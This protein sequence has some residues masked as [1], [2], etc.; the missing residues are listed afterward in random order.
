MDD[1]LNTKVINNTIANGIAT[2]I[3]L[4]EQGEKLRRVETNINHIDDTLNYSDF[5]VK[6]MES[7]Y[8]NVKKNLGYL[9]YRNNNN[10]ISDNDTTPVNIDTE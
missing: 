1:N 4:E 9:F 5:I 3:K 10:D 2:L 7:L 6:T 8:S